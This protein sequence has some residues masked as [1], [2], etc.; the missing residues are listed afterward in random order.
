MRS[1]LILRNNKKRDTCNGNKRPKILN[2]VTRVI[3]LPT[4][5]STKLEPTH[6]GCL[7]ILGMFK[8]V[9]ASTQARL[10]LK[11]NRL[12]SLDDA[13]TD[14]SRVRED[15]DS[16]NEDF[17]LDLLH[18]SSAKERKDLIRIKTRFTRN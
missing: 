2:I 17:H 15:F 16:I 9:R 4:V 18:C 12:R 7:S 6:K 8:S 10:V 11:H 14:T 3:C 5:R 13:T 1:S